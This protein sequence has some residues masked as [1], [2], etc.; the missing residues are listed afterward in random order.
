MLKFV[1]TENFLKRTVKKQ[2]DKLMLKCFESN[3]YIV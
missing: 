1:F 2:I 3:C